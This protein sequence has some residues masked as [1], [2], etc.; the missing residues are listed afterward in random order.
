MLQLEAKSLLSALTVLSCTVGDFNLSQ[1]IISAYPNTLLSHP[2]A[3]KAAIIHAVKVLVSTSELHNLPMSSK[4]GHRCLQLLMETL[5]Q[6][7]PYRPDDLRA[8]S[9]SISALIHTVVDEAESRKFFAADQHFDAYHQTAD[10]LYGPNVVDT[11][12][13][14][15]LDI[16]EAGKC[17]S[18]NLWT[19]AVMHTMRVLETGL[20]RLADHVDVA[21]GDNWN[22][23]LNDI[24]TSLRAVQRKSNGAAAEQWAAEAGTHLRFVKNAWRN[25]AMHTHVTYDEARARAI[26]ENARSFMQHLAEKLGER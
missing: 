20:S 9:N 8:L 22:K 12:P 11:F 4:Q 5:P 10:T 16:E 18:F 24:E 13:E 17:L 1:K 3:T 6:S 15:S 14:A 23:T 21:T 19:A 25:Q 2:I 7:T 26:F